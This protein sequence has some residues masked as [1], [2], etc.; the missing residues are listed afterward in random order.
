[1]LAVAI[2]NLGFSQYCASKAEELTKRPS[3]L[4]FKL[5]ELD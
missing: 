5:V 4:G 2:V 3:N 1:M